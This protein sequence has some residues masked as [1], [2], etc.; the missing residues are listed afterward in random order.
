MWSHY[1][2]I[3]ETI[4]VKLITIN[5]L[6]LW[7]R[8]FISVISVTNKWISTHLC[9]ESPTSLFPTKFQ[10]KIKPRSYVNQQVNPTFAPNFITITLIRQ[11]SMQSVENMPPLPPWHLLPHVLQI[12][13]RNPKYDQ[14][15]S[16]GH[17]NEENLQSTTKMPGSPKFDLFH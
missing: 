11:N 7:S 13:P 15:Q 4:Y 5:T 12:M 3:S 10:V 17:H 1:N 6:Q 2:I 16:K 8:I 9:R 14:F